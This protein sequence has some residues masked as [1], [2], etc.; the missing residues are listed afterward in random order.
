MKRKSIE[1]KDRIDNQRIIVGL[2]LLVILFPIYIYLISHKDW[3]FNLSDKGSIGEAIGGITAPIIGIIGAV[4]IYKSFRSQVN[5][6]EYV[7]NQNEFKLMFDLIVEMKRDIFHLYDRRNWNIN[8]IRTPYLS[9]LNDGDIKSIPAVFKRKLLFIFND[10]I[11]L[12]NRTKG[13]D[14]LTENDEKALLNSLDNI[15][16]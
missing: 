12:Y 2:V 14:K 13:S 10:Y 11:F 8:S 9:N 15:Y 5:A 16:D 6:N 3:F 1:D 4:L 7:S